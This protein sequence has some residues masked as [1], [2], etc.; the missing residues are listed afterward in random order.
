MPKWFQAEVAN[1]YATG[2]QH[3]LRHIL[4]R[5]ACDFVFQKF[6]TFPE[7]TIQVP[8]Q[9]AINQP[10]AIMSVGPVRKETCQQIG[11]PSSFVEGG[12]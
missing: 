6:V 5:H 3:R 10:L 12:E 11:P 4:H 7:G 8:I 1:D 2:A 9:E